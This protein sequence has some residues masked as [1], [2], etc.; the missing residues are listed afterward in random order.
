MKISILALIITFTQLINLNAQVTADFSSDIQEACESSSVHFTDNSIPSSGLSYFWDFGNGHTSTLKNPTTVYTNTGFYTVKLIVSDGV[1]SDTA[2]KV[3]YIKIWL[4]PVA[5]FQIT[6]NISGCVPLNTSFQNM[7]S[8]GNGIITNYE[9]DFG[10]GTT[11]NEINPVH[12][13]NFQSNYAT[14]LTVTDEHGC[15]SSIVSDTIVS[16]FK[17]QASFLSDF[18]SNCT[19]ESDVTFYNNSEGIGNL[20]YLWDFGDDNS[21]AEQN[22]SH[23]YSGNGNYSV[24]LTVTDSHSCKD[25]LIEIDYIK[26]SGV[27]ASFEVN[28]DTVCS[29]ENVIFTNTS[30]NAY[31]FVWN[32]GDGNFSEQKNPIHKY[33]EP[34]SY[35]VTL[36]TQHMSGCR[37]SVN[38]NIFVENIIADFELSDNYACELPAVIKYT[39]LSQNAVNYEWHFGNGEVSAEKNPQIVYYKQGSYSDTLIVYSPHGCRDEK[40]IDSSFTAIIPRAYFTPN[41]WS[42][43]WDV[44]GCIP[45]TINFKDM[46]N[47]ENKYDSIKSRYWI[48]GNGFESKEKNPSI[49]YEDVGQYLVKYYFET[50]KGCISRTYFSTVKTGTRQHADFFKKLPDT[51]CASQQVQ[52]FDNSQ[53]SSLISEWYWRFGDST[54]SMKKDPVHMYVDTGYMDVKL[55]VYYNGCGVKETKQNFIY[56]KG[57]VSKISYNTHCD[58]PYNVSFLSNSKDAEKVYWDF[59]DGSE[60]DSVNFNPKHIFPDN[61]TFFVNLTAVNNT[62]G[63]TYNSEEKVIITDIK[64]DIIIDTTFGCENLKVNLSSEGSQDASSFIN[65]NTNAKYF[66]NFG[67]GKFEHTNYGQVSHYYQKKGIYNLKLLV[68]DFRG[69]ADSIF[70][71]IK[72]YK[73]KPDFNVQTITGCIPRNIQFDNTTVG[74]TIIKQWIW[75]FG[76]GQYSYEK[77]PSH[78]YDRFGQYDVSLKAIDTLGCISDTLKINYVKVIK[79]IPDFDAQNRLHC[80]GDTVRFIPSDTYDVASYLWDFGDGTTSTDIFPN[81]FYENEGK[82]N[83]SLTLLD[84]NGCDSSKTVLNYVSMQN[85]PI[86]DFN[87]TETTANCYPMTVNFSDITQNENITDWYWNFGDGETSS[88]LKFPEHIYTFPGIFDVT[89]NVSTVNGCSA[90]I[91]KSEYIDLRG[92]YAEIS[93]PDTACKH[94]ELLFIAENKRDIYDLQWIFGDGSTADKDSSYHSYSTGGLKRP[95]L[96]IKSDS[97][98]TCDI[99][100]E[101]SVF[102][103]DISSDIFIP[104]NQ[105]AGCNPFTVNMFNNCTDA[106]NWLWN[107]DDGTYSTNPSTMHTF[108]EPGIYNIKLNVEDELGCKDSSTVQIESYSAPT[109]KTMNDTLICR[110][111]EI[112]LNAVGAFNY[113]WFPK[114]WLNEQNVNKPFT[115]PDSTIVYNVIGEDINGC[116]NNSNVTIKVQQ[117]PNINLKD[118]AIII[119][120]NVVLNAYSKDIK[121]YSWYPDYNINCTDCSEVILTPLEPTTYEVTVTDTANCF[122]KTFETNID[123]LR[124]YTV[125]VPDA[126]TPNGDGYNDILYVRGWGIDQ[127]ISFKIFNRYGE[128]VFET[129][130]KNIGWDGTYKGKK[131]GTETFTYIVIVQTYDNS[132]LTKRGAIKLLK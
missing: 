126:F 101:D 57:P 35:T 91:S 102:I 15:V 4:P 71:K 130:D 44:K 114:K 52:F 75:N 36:V 56:I 63:C 73:P 72:I 89:L 124:K 99:L 19:S 90:N 116:V 27:L 77:I 43:P 112:Q 9:W 22:P 50:N 59:G 67:D 1:N 12:T 104:N 98:G 83:V 113:E 121:T 76:D 10:D 33:T 120:E 87:S 54:Y 38:K 78:I 109:I 49:T 127:L 132:F 86:P 31:S 5:D 123:I 47:Y 3:D 81:H 65:N 7:S 107:F 39:N 110:G 94:D 115:S 32:F 111:N 82:Y 108:T 79:P 117:E 70:R 46:S 18:V 48:F 122:T 28:K 20:S 40:I 34:G 17:P 69:C 62:N 55:Q 14:S 118:T 45:L 129:N 29:D 41:Q 16:V 61:K 8:E 26:I 74:D 6:E 95:T 88:H 51:I 92:P 13:Y 23:H 119:G 21:S 2:E 128:L 66:W 131:Q 103:P 37:D 60:I 58:A 68:K 97:I 25:T 24:S 105:F 100:L 85:Y 106:N 64:A 11:S 125:D 80:F 30:E 96:L 53:D 42:N 84:N 93:V